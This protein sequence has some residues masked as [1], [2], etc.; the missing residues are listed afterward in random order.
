MS[1]FKKKEE[2]KMERMGKLRNSI[3]DN[4]RRRVSLEV[5]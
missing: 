4:A 2:E 5:D 3:R 1:Y